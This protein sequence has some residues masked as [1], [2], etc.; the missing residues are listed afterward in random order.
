[1]KLSSQIKQVHEDNVTTESRCQNWFI[2][3]RS[4]NFGIED[5][6]HSIIEVGGEREES[7]ETD[8]DKIKELTDAKR[9]MT[10]PKISERFIH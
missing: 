1:M 6:P 5:V 3:F 2:K 8:E 10:S 7:V 9:R 4:N